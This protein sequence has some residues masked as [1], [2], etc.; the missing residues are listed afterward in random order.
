MQLPPVATT[1]VGS[2]PR[3]S[4]LANMD[5]LDWTFRLEGPPLREAQDDATIVV[6]HEQEQTGLDLLTDGEQRRPTF[7]NHFLG[8]LEGIDLTN[9]RAKGIRRRTERQVPPVTGPVRRRA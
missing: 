2:Y 9:R 4:W 7:I 8:S 5:A 1:T 3:P 6:L